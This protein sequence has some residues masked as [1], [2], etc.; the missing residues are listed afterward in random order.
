MSALS[1]VVASHGRALR[2]RWLLNALAEQTFADFELIVGHDGGPQTEA[3]LASHPLARE[4]RLRWVASAPGSAPPGANRNR[5]LALATAPTVVFTDDD[6]RPPADW[7]AR[8]HAAV[9]AH[10]GAIVQGPVLADPVEA[11]MLRSAF[12]RTQHY[13]EVPR[14]WAECANI[15]YPR[16]ALVAFREDLR[17]GEDADLCLRVRARGVAFVGVPEMWSWHSVTEGTLLSA[18]RDVGRWGDLAVLVRAH[19]ELRVQFTAGVFWTPA[20]AWLLALLATPA[21]PGGGWRRTWALGA[22]AGWAASRRWRGGG[23][24]GKLRHARELPALALLDAVELAV[25]A[26]ASVRHRTVLL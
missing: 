8:V 20:H 23:V 22:G 5:A 17:T 7:L 13:T 19:P 21:W 18:L 10:P 26:G 6:C 24:R 3:V 14:P 2:L 1:V 15:A 12:P 4:G 9:R 11:V 16:E 25:L